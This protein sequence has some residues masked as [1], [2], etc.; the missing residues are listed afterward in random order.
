MGC[1]GAASLGAGGRGEAEQGELFRPRKSP[2]KPVG[3][4]REQH[5]GAMEPDPDTGCWETVGLLIWHELG[6]ALVT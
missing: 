2:G 3:V 4:E 5:P 1:V 6:T